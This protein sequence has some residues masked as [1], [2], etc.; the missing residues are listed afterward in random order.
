MN[1]VYE[2]SD[3]LSLSGIQHFH[4]CRRQWALIHIR[5]VWEENHLTAKG[6]IVH[7]KAHDPEIRE[8]RKELIISRGMPVSS[9]RLGISGECDVVEFHND[10]RGISI[11]GYEGKYIPVPV[12]YKRGSGEF[13]ESD[14]LQL[15]AQAM[16]LEEMLCT[17]IEYGFLYYHQTNK[18][19]KVDFN[20]NIRFSVRMIFSEMHDYYRRNHVPAA[21]KGKKCNGCSLYEFC[22]SSVFK[23]RSA[24][25]YLKK[26]IEGDFE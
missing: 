17:E 2:E 8:S 6:Q 3:Y 7:A 24:K 19:I 11:H 9:A 14:S 23:K 10:S 4:F 13:T 26:Y 12:E 20:E 15:C 25:E 21:R 16:C 22:E 1:N 18:R 5:K